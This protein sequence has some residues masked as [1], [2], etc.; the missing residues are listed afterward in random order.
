MRPPRYRYGVAHVN[1]NPIITM[2]TPML[3]NASA[4]NFDFV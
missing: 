3:P 4:E 1:H 2:T